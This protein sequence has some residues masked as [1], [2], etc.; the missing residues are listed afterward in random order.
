MSALMVYACEDRGSFPD[1]L[2]ALLEG[3]DNE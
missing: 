1:S 2:V 3:E